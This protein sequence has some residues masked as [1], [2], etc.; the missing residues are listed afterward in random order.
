MYFTHLEFFEQCFLKLSVFDKTGKSKVGLETF[1][2]EGFIGGSLFLIDDK[3]ILVD[4]TVIALHFYRTEFSGF[5]FTLFEKKFFF[6]TFE[7]KI[8]Q[9]TESSFVVS[10]SLHSFFNFI[11]I[12][13]K[14]YIFYLNQNP[15]KIPF[16]LKIH[17]IWTDK[18][19]YLLIW[20][21]L[22]E[23]LVKRLRKQEI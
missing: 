10:Y 21:K 18:G 23:L 17:K 8:S 7:L 15:W 19:V 11:E 12:I 9:W 14:V 5:S 22:L 1:Q 4:L 20:W 6:V 3:K 16:F 2:N 13:S